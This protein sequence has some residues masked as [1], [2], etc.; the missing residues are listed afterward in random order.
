MDRRYGA[1]A[2][3]WAYL[4]VLKSAGST[5]SQ[6]FDDNA[7][8]ALTGVNQFRLRPNTFRPSN[9]PTFLLSPVCLADCAAA[10]CFLKPDLLL[11]S[12]SSQGMDVF[13]I[14]GFY[15]EVVLE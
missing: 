15:Y 10:L 2:R 6:I 4:K 3:K 8:V 1:S 12:H 7:I 11:F 5:V 13:L 14:I 9:W